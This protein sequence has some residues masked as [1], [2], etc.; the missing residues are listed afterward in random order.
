MEAAGE[1]DI[2]DNLV[3]FCV[4]WTTIRTVEPA[5][6]NFIAAWNDHHLPGCRGGV[7]N[8]LA[9]RTNQTTQLDPAIIPTTANAVA[10][11]EQL[12]CQLTRESQFGYDPLIS[13]PHLS[14]LRERDFYLRHPSMEEV[15]ECVL[16]GNTA[17]FK[18]AIKD[19]IELTRSFSRLEPDYN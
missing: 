15:M 5:V 3:K 18:Q 8:V 6:K 7:P 2:T 4:S 11:H 13:Y 16:H 17:V 14:R 12:G 10:L 1:M 19:F 9:S